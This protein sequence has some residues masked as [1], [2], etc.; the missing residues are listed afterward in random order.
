[1]N[2]DLSCQTFS[3]AE[4]RYITID[5]TTRNGKTELLDVT[6]MPQFSFARISMDSLQPGTYTLYGKAH[7]FPGGYEITQP[8]SHE[9]SISDH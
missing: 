2:F 8:F 9:F 5:S 7:A 1:V 4:K 3:L 6:T